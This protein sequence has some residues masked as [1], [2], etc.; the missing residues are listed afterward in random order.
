MSLTIDVDSHFD[1]YCAIGLICFF[2]FTHQMRIYA[3]LNGLAI[4]VAFLSLS[5]SR[6][7]FPHSI[8]LNK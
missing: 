8:D 6:F 5:L 4:F 1:Q 3:L 2:L 7:P